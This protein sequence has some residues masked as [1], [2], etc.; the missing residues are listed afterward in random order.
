MRKRKIYSLAMAVLFIGVLTVGTGYAYQALYTAS[1]NTLDHQY[2]TVNAGGSGGSVLEHVQVFD[3][4]IVGG[5]T[6]YR[7]QTVGTTSYVRLNEEP[8]PIAISGHDPEQTY[9]FRLNAALPVLLNS[10]DEDPGCWCRFMFQLEKTTDH[11]KVYGVTTLD[12]SGEHP[13]QGSLYKFYLMVDEDEYQL[14][15]EEAV[16]TAGSY[17][18]TVLILMDSDGVSDG[19]T[20]GCDVDKTHFV[21]RFYSASFE[22]SFVV[23]G[24]S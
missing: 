15:T 18:L 3:T 21:D 1:D 13:T 5:E 22:M 17:A 23:L 9:N 8:I 2:V 7:V 16:I 20:I 24:A 11:S 14:D 6:I 10:D 4:K 12:T 19:Y